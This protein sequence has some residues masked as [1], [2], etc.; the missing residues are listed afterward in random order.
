MRP[1][2]SAS[3]VVPLTACATASPL[4]SNSDYSP[5]RVA[6]IARGFELRDRYHLPTHV[7][8]TAIYVDS[9]VVHHVDSEAS[10]IAWRDEAGHWQWSQATEVGPGGLL[11]IERSLEAHETRTLT[12]A[13]AEAV[14]RLIRNPRLYGGEVRRTGEIGVGAPFHVMA[15]VTPFGRTTVRWDG[16][17]R[18]PSGA[19]ADIILGRD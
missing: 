12:D 5:P 10:T 4:P 17:L 8:A 18:G 15:I 6:E 7:G 14:E 11:T 13:E 16:R 1:L 9:V 19:V 3:F 2:V